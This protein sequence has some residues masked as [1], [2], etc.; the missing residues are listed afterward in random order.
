LFSKIMKE[1]HKDIPVHDFYPS[2]GSKRSQGMHEKREVYHPL[3]AIQLL[4]LLKREQN[5]ENGVTGVQGD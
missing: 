2:P 4:F 3:V 1:A 5:P